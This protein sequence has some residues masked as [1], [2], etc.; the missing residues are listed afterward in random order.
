MECPRN[1]VVTETQIWILRQVCVWYANVRTAGDI[2]MQELVLSSSLD[3][4]LY[5]NS[6]SSYSSDLAIIESRC[7][8]ENCRSVAMHAHG[9]H[10]ATSRPNSLGPLDPCSRGRLHEV[11]I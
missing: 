7:A 11:A 2:S 10:R 6:I 4:F 1:M 5:S 9:S 8:E 3:S